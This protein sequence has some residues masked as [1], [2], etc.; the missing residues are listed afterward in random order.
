VL[1]CFGPSHLELFSRLASFSPKLRDLRSCCHTHQ[2]HIY[3]RATGVGRNTHIA[4]HPVD[5]D[6]ACS[7][8]AALVPRRQ[9][10]MV[11]TGGGCI[12]FRRSASA[13]AG[14]RC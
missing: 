11:E 12:F 6:D 5:D 14:S 4:T 10:L 2:H 1:S 9:Q 3:I 7:A 8:V 13:A